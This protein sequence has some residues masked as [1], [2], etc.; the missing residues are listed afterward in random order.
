MTP[1]GRILYRWARN[2]AEFKPK[3][4]RAVAEVFNAMADEA[5]YAEDKRSYD[6]AAQMLW[7]MA[8]AAQEL[9]NA[10]PV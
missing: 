5:P 9:R 4:L 10:V 1:E 3:V 2:H 7:D 8:N 6:E